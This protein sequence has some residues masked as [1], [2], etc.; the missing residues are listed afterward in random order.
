MH[1]LLLAGQFIRLSAPAT[2]VL[3]LDPW[4]TPQPKAL[5]WAL[6]RLERWGDDYP[7]QPWEEELVF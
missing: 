4:C 7:R 2:Y 6:G 1:T 5:P 3:I